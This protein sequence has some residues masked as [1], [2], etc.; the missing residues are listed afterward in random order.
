MIIQKIKKGNKEDIFPFFNEAKIFFFMFYQSS[1]VGHIMFVCLFV[2]MYVCLVDSSQTVQ[3][4]A[5]KF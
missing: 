2:Y 1:A 3:P 4:R 5:F